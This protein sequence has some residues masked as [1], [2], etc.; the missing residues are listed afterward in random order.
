MGCGF[1][2]DDSKAS[3]EEGILDKAKVT[4]GSATQSNSNGSISGKYIFK[5]LTFGNSYSLI[6]LLVFSICC[7]SGLK[8]NCLSDNCPPNV[9]FYWLLPHEYSLIELCVHRSGQLSFN[10]LSYDLCLM[11]SLFL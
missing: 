11:S 9:K 1:S 4:K 5:T 7:L 6:C 10:F 8:D 2:A 3:D